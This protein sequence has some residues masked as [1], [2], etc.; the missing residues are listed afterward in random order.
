M[1][2]A[3]NVPESNQHPTSCAS[4]ESGLPP[5]CQMLYVML[6][7]LPNMRDRPSFLHTQQLLVPP[8]VH[9]CM[10]LVGHAYVASSHATPES[11]QGLVICDA[12]IDWIGLGLHVS[13]QAG[14]W[15][16]WKT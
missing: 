15:A 7:A 16:N 2:Q 1:Y 3:S 4:H 8:F 12:G 13:R 11:M 9:V 10:L 5:L 14:R 6:D